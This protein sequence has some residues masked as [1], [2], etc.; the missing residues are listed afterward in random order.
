MEYG[1]LEE[2]G[3]GSEEG[4]AQLDSLVAEEEKVGGVEEVKG[5]AQLDS[6]VAA[7]MPRVVLLEELLEVPDHISECPSQVSLCLLSLTQL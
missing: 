3:G 2:G 7:A 5:I 6:L 1:L 4:I